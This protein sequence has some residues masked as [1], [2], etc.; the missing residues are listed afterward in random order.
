MAGAS[1]SKATSEETNPQEPKSKGDILRENKGFHPGQQ[2]TSQGRQLGRQKNS[3]GPDN[4]K[5]KGGR[6]YLLAAFS[7]NKARKTNTKDRQTEIR[8]KTYPQ[9]LNDR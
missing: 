5:M 6:S 4:S 8:T 7:A 9:Q 2:Q 3:T 1:D